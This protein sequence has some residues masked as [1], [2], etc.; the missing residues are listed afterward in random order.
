MIKIRRNIKRSE[1][2]KLGIK[3]SSKARREHG[4]RNFAAKSDPLRKSL[5]A[6]KIASRCKKVSQPPSAL[7]ENF[8]SYEEV[9][10][11][12]SVISQPSTPISQLRNGCEASKPWNPPFRNRDAIWKGVLQLW[13]HPLAHECHSEAPYTH[14]TAAKWLR[15]LHTLKSFSVHTMNRHVTAAPPLDTFFITSQSSNYAY[16]IMFWSSGSQ[17]SRASNGARFGFETKELWLF[18]D[19]CANHERK[20]RTSILLLL[21]TFLKHF[22]GLKLCIPYF[23]SNLGK[24]RV[25]RFKWCT[26]WS[27]NEE[28]AAVWRRTR[29]ALAGISQ[30]RPHFEGCFAAAKPPFGTR[31]P[32]C[33]AVG[34]FHSCE[35]GYENP[36]PPR[37]PSSATK[38]L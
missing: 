15:N 25:Q 16:Y 22:L 24:S 12:M 32:L 23:V 38:M 2:R 34:P 21:D 4:L 3:R 10:W 8:R 14:F 27:W 30:P 6:A 17:E 28:V 19:D 33:S 26:I 31:V 5:P 37:N 11:H 7:C 36:S 1:I 35:M 20:C 9:P 29:K 13:N 18:E